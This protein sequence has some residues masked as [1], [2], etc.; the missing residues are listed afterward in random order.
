MLSKTLIVFAQ[1]N[2]RISK[3]FG[4]V[5]SRQVLAFDHPFRPLWLLLRV[6]KYLR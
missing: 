1:E 2:C 4:T 5:R 6:Q 3:S